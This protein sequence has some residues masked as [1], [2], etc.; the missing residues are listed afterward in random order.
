MSPYTPSWE[1]LPIAA[2]TSVYFY[3]VLRMVLKLIPY[4]GAMLSIMTTLLIGWFGIAVV[5]SFPSSTSW[6]PFQSLLIFL[7]EAYLIVP[8]ELHMFHIL[9]IWYGGET[10]GKRFL[11]ADKRAA[12][13]RG[14]G[15]RARL[16][17]GQ[18]TQW[19]KYHYQGDWAKV[20]RKHLRAILLNK[21][22]DT[23][24]EMNY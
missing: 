22:D 13:V 15:I 4:H 17:K 21:F 24:N 8:L 18:E 9:Y 23:K 14:K 3:A 11:D 12:S 2:M 10:F 5:N 1:I 6:T 19:K 7:I 16:S 20:R